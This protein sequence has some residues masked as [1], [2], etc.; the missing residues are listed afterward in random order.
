M[1]R[2]FPS[3]G[4][5]QGEDVLLEAFCC[6]AVSD[7]KVS[8]KELDA[9]TS[10]CVSHGY[11]DALSELADKLL[12]ICKHIHK[13]GLEE[14]IVFTAERI[15]GVTP[16]LSQVFVSNA[17]S[18]VESDGSG[19]TDKQATAEKLSKAFSEDMLEIDDDLL[20]IDAADDE[21]VPPMASTQVAEASNQV[22][23]ASNQV[24]EA[25]NQVAEASTKEAGGVPA[26]GLLADLGKSI[27]DTCCFYAD[28]ARIGNTLAI[29]EA[30]KPA[31]RTAFHVRYKRPLANYINAKL[32]I[33]VFEGGFSVSST[34]PVPQL[35]DISWSDL[36]E[37]RIST[38]RLLG[39]NF[40]KVQRKDDVA[41]CLILIPGDL[42]NTKWLPEW[43]QRLQM[44]AA[45]NLGLAAVGLE[46]D[47]GGTTGQSNELTS[48]DATSRSDTIKAA[49]GVAKF[50]GKSFFSLPGKAAQAG[51]DKL[52]KKCEKCEM[53]AG[54]QTKTQKRPSYEKVGTG[55]R[56][57]NSGEVRAAMP[58]LGKQQEWSP[59]PAT[60]VHYPEEIHFKCMACGHEWFEVSVSKH[61]KTY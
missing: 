31:V 58:I 41:E 33:I 3:L 39:S 49:W 9:I 19:L 23:E 6:I 28:N 30:M 60:I 43:I 57:V 11:T 46:T 34:L 27:A 54:A 35:W 61:V 20:G 26:V 7:R 1:T 37:S 44:V 18:V 14:Y 13:E 5:V 52:T 51:K 55:W 2:Y 15:R 36:A 16:T 48:G 17:Q 38:T 53:M 10:I 47:A 40:L 45:T 25:S 56:N 32:S 24:A 59:V 42:I 21:E 50:V 22:A 4:E 29:G 12:E 8:R